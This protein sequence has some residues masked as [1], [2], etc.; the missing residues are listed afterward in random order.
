MVLARKRGFTLIELLVVIAIIAILAA[1][2]FPVFA[3]IKDRARRTACTSNLRQLFY[4]FRQYG[5][6]YDG[7]MPSL[8]GNLSININNGWLGGPWPQAIWPYVKNQQLF[9]CPSDV[10]T[11]SSTWNLGG[12]TWWQKTGEHPEN[13]GGTSYDWN[14]YAFAGKNPDNAPPVD[15]GGGPHWTGYGC[16]PPGYD[17]KNRMFLV[18]G[19]AFHTEAKTHWGSSTAGF[20]ILHPYGDVKYVTNWSAHAFQWW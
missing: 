19:T 2:L 7:V 8:G 1:I 10:Y 6:D 18:D 4:A 13:M 17:T 9:R 15:Y 12:K 5:D 11:T 3:R 20:N 16:P 14:S